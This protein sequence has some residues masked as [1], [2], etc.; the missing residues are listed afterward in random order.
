[1]RLARDTF[2]SHLPIKTRAS[3]VRIRGSTVTVDT[4]DFICN[5]GKL[6]L[7]CRAQGGDKITPGW[8]LGRETM[9]RGMLCRKLADPARI[10]TARDENE[11]DA[12][13]DGWATQTTF[14]SRNRDVRLKMGGVL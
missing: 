13:P 4:D 9:P 3:V 7:E 6:G 1:V 10:Y 2:R 11:D 8:Q 12:T 5:V 14:G